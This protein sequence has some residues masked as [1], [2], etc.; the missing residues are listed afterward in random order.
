MSC[1]YK[2]GYFYRTYKMINIPASEFKTYDMIGVKHAVFQ[3]DDTVNLY[4][5]DDPEA[6][7][8]TLE[9]TKVAKQRDLEFNSRNSRKKKTI[10]IDVPLMGIGQYSNN[11]K[12]F[13]RVRAKY[14]LKVGFK[15]S[16]DGVRVDHTMEQIEVIYE[17]ML[18][19][20]ESLVEQQE[21]TQ[22]AINEAETIEELDA[23]DVSGNI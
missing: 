7:E 3:S 22:E 17:A 6:I 19:R 5:I 2:T 18:E 8:K 13:N 4:Y 21:E 11:T 1:L 20:Y 10:D 14:G 15:I 9:I 23:I 16:R 12:T